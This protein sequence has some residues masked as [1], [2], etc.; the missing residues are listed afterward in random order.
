MDNPGSDN[1]LNSTTDSKNDVSNPTHNNDLQQ[2]IDS[3]N[4]QPMEEMHVD[5]DPK[6]RTGTWMGPD[7]ENRSLQV[8]KEQKN[9]SK[10]AGRNFSLVVF[11]LTITMALILQYWLA[12]KMDSIWVWTTGCEEKD[13]APHFDEICRGNTMVLRYSF[14]LA[15]FYFILAIICKADPSFQ[16]REMVTKTI[17]ITSLLV[18]TIFT[19]NW[20]Y[21]LHFY[22]WV[23]RIG[24][25]CYIIAQ[26]VILIDLA[27]Y[28]NDMLYNGESIFKDKGT[29][30]LVIASALGFLVSI[31]IW[32]LLYMY[33]GSCSS[34]IALITVT[35]IGS[36]I[37][38]ICQLAIVSERGTLFTTSVLTC[39]VSYLCY[40][41]ISLNPRESCNPFAIKENNLLQI[42][43]GLLLVTLTILKVCWDSSKS[44]MRLHA[45]KQV[46]VVEDRARANDLIAGGDGKNVQAGLDIYELEEGDDDS[47]PDGIY[48]KS[49]LMLAFVAMYFGMTLTG[50][51][52]IST[53][54]STLT[55]RQGDT[56][57]Y[58]QITAQWLAMLLYCWTVIAPRLFPDRDFS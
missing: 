50:W 12:A 5:D 31:A 34:S 1:V 47:D 19:P 51:A 2:D 44:V 6:A 28:W 58:L 25:F 56:A 18:I 29:V 21:D 55:Q 24:G 33:F 38:L 40:G 57:M 32:V 39:Y 14:A 45:G 41:A 43:F 23:A 53:E 16:N 30:V 17:I 26:Q 27:Y 54:G 11:P 22:G 20:I 8:H 4:L 48:W 3:N 46:R 13:E 49:N 15:L 9:I 35:I 52:T 7:V 42:I 36:V 37:C 10:N